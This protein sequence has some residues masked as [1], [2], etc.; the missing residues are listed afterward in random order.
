MKENKQ[1]WC[2]GCGLVQE[3]PEER[4]GLY[5]GVVCQPDDPHA[6][7][8]HQEV[9]V[10][11][12]DQEL[13]ISITP[14]EVHAD[15]LGPAQLLGCGTCPIAKR[16]TTIFRSEY[17]R[18]FSFWNRQREIIPEHVTPRPPYCQTPEKAHVIGYSPDAKT[19]LIVAY[20]IA[21]GAVL[22][23][24]D[25]PPYKNKVHVRV[26]DPNAQPPIGG[27][28][29]LMANLNDPDKNIWAVPLNM[30]PDK[31][32]LQYKRKNLSGI[33]LYKLFRGLPIAKTQYEYLYVRQLS[34]DTLNRYAHDPKSS[35]MLKDFIAKY[36]KMRIGS[37]R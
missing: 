12:G 29:D 3:A 5:W 37:S 20:Y 33:L 34:D 19:N 7:Y 9:S 6:N 21:F 35:H 24:T 2:G 14:D 31:W 10:H 4:E 8:W 16:V 26:F 15:K 25:I 1:S 28:Y 36:R 23:E 27:S 17:A 13:V 32:A 22:I 30:S 11:K 18:L